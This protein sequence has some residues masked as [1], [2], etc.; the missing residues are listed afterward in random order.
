MCAMTASNEEYFLRGHLDVQGWVSESA[1]SLVLALDRLQRGKGVKGG[2]CEIGVHHGRYFIALA[3]LRRPGE[4]ALAVDV[5]GRQELNVDRSGRGDRDAFER[6]L[7]KWNAVDHLVVLEADSLTLT[8]ARVIKELGSRVRLFSVDGSHTVG[9]TMNDIR[10]AEACLSS[11]GAIIVDDFLNPHWPGVLEAAVKILSDTDS[12]LVPV[13]FH[14]DKLVLVR[15]KDYEEYFKLF[16]RDVIAFSSDVKRVTF[17]GRDCFSAVFDPPR[18]VLPVIG[19][20]TQERFIRKGVLS[21]TLT[22]TQGWTKREGTGVWTCGP[23]AKLSW[24]SSGLHNARSFRLALECSSFVGEGRPRQSLLI[25][26]NGVALGRAEVEAK[27]N[28]FFF[29]VAADVISESNEITVTPHSVVS[30]AQAGVTADDRPLG[31]YVR[32]LAL[33]FN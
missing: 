33:L 19:T 10:V 23:S 5:F 11:G 15:Q 2:V 24:S 17:C 7:A 22:S 9:H 31:V 8:G 6:N 4:G 20:R 1:L 14:R 3:A 29:D 18:D 25:E 26:C 13:V 32:H 12:S 28:W 21:E 30:P 16:E 27:Q